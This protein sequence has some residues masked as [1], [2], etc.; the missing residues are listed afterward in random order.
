MG[1]LEEGAEQAED[2]EPETMTKEK[3][4]VAKMVGDARESGRNPGSSQDDA[5]RRGRGRDEPWSR[6]PL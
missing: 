6:S 2:R 3:S 4:R 5:P 1:A